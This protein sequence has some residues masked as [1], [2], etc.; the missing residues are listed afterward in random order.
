MTFT[1]ATLLR[2]AAGRVVDTPGLREF[3][4]TN[5]NTGEL[6]LFY[7]DFAAFREKCKFATCTHRHE[8]KCAVRTAVEQG[9][10]DAGRYE[11]YLSLLREAWNTEQRQK[12]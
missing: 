1:S 7:P 6:S 10:L 11:R 5:F 8:P 2:V 12:P 3:G 4:L 9:L